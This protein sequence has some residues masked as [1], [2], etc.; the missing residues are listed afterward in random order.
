MGR[1]DCPLKTWGR[2]SRQDLWHQRRSGFPSR[3]GAERRLDTVVGKGLL[4]ERGQRQS[5]P[6]G[7]TQAQEHRL[8]S[9][10]PL[11]SHGYVTVHSS[12]EKSYRGRRK[13]TQ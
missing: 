6:G 13:V 1:H 5:R 7:C 12:L 8:P 9:E 2:K 10:K 4:E 11:H 3:T